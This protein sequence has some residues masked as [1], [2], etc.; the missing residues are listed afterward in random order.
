MRETSINS[1]DKC[2]NLTILAHYDPKVCPTLPFWVRRHFPYEW[3]PL[4]AAFPL[5]GRKIPDG[6]GVWCWAHVWG[7]QYNSNTLRSPQNAAKSLIQVQILPQ[8]CPILLKKGS[9]ANGNP[10]PLWVVGITGKYQGS[11]VQWCVPTVEITCSWLSLWRENQSAAFW[12]HSSLKKHLSFK[13]RYTPNGED[14]LLVVRLK[15]KYQK[16]LRSFSV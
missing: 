15:G 5:A 7:S 2:V 14:A 8:P 1:V 13:K 6:V 16:Y 12:G 3:G 11:Y 9:T 4:E 10:L